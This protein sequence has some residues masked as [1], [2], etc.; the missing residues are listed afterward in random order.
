MIGEAEGRLNN[1]LAPPAA[2]APE[3]AESGAVAAECELRVEKCS[4]PAMYAEGENSPVVG[5]TKSSRRQ[6]S[7]TGRKMA[8]GFYMSGK[9]PLRVL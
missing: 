4:A 5:M 2:A 8:T 6:E 7:F 3:A 1:L 9:N